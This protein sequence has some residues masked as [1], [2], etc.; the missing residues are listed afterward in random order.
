MRLNR[1]TC[2][3]C[4]GAIVTIDRD[5]GVTPFM[6]QCRATQGCRGS[7]Y[8]SFYRGVDGAP[9]YE[10]RKATPAEY[11]KASPGMREHFDNGGLDIH[12]L[13]VGEKQG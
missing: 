6:L 12:A 8:S 13:T 2:S 9:T 10:W 3:K 5:E 11:A 1:Y 4:A 7:M